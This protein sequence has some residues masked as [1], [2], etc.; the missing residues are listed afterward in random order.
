MVAKGQADVAVSDDAWPGIHAA[1]Q[2]VERIVS[3]GDTVYG[4]NTGFGALVRERISTDDLAQ[5]QINLIRSHAT[6][7]GDLMT[8][9]AVRAMMMVRLNSLCKGHSGIHP[10]CIRQLVLYLNHN[11]HPAVPRIGSLGASG[12]LAPLSHLALTLIGEGGVLVDGKVESTADFLFSN[13]LVP[14]ELTAKDG[15]SLINGTSQMTAY[16][17]LAQQELASVLLLADVILAMSMDARSCSLTPSRPEVHDARPIRDNNGSLNAFARCSAVR[18][19]SKTTPRATGF[20]TP[21]LSVAPPRSTAPFTNP[22]SG[23]AICSQ[24]K[25]TAPPTTR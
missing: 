18:K 14:V 13:G 10:D 1:R 8:V 23:W 11:V 5:L 3:T 21:I 9:E 2:V 20:K 17:V 16:A 22:S 6:G 19:Y 24:G 15:L 12:D 7:V 4:I 25:S